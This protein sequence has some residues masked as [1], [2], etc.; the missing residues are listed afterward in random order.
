[1]AYKKVTMEDL[2][3]MDLDALERELQ[4]LE[5]KLQLH[6]QAAQREIDGRKELIKLIRVMKFGKPPRKKRQP[7]AVS[8]AAAPP[9]IGRPAPLAPAVVTNGS[10]AV[11]ATGPTAERIRTM[12]KRR[13]KM[14]MTEVAKTLSLTEDETSFALNNHDCFDMDIKGLWSVV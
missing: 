14:K 5:G 6:V 3:Q 4:E 1:M 8:A 7:K 11:P 10:A 9:L 2:K 12:L 13:G